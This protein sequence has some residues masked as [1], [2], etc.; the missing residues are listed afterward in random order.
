MKRLTLD[1]IAST[2]FSYETNVFDEEN[3]IF[4]LKLIELIKT[5]DFEQTDTFT[6]FKYILGCK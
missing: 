2:V 5:V 4:L 6:K 3:N 1:V